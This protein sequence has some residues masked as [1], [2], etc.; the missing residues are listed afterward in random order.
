M[1]N[2]MDLKT[3]QQMVLK[4]GIVAE[5]VENMGDGI[6]AQVKYI[7]APESPSLVGT[8]ELCHC[9]EAVRLV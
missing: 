9:E 7:E 4:G 3:G 6:W 1:I 5:V 8:E 2:F